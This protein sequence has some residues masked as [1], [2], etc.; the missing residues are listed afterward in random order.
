MRGE[1]DD[2]LARMARREE[3]Q[4]RRAAAGRGGVDELI[5]AVQRVVARHP[6]L[7]VTMSVAQGG[8]TSVVRVE[9]AGGSIAVAPAVAPAVEASIVPAAVDPPPAR[10]DTAPAAGPR[11]AWPMSGKTVPGWAADGAAMDPA[12]RLAELIRRD[13]SV[14]D[15]NRPGRSGGGG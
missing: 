11:D 2:T 15:A 12:A 14:L 8:T 10:P 1:L 13:P 7:G 6:G 9:W 4:R 5:E 3:L